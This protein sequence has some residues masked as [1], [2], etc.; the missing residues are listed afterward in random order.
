MLADD[1]FKNDREIRKSFLKVVTRDRSSRTMLYVAL[2]IEEN[3]LKNVILDKMKKLPYH[4]LVIISFWI[5]ANLPFKKYILKCF[6][7][8]KHLY[9]QL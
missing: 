6:Q 7:K 5:V 8:I 2:T 3:D 1:F 9:K 4:K